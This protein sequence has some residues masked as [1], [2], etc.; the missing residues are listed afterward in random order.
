MVRLGSISA[1]HDPPPPHA[2]AFITG[3]AINTPI[4]DLGRRGIRS[5]FW[6]RTLL[7]RS[8]VIRKEPQNQPKQTFIFN[9]RPCGPEGISPNFF[10]HPYVERPPNFSG[11]HITACYNS[12]SYGTLVATIWCYNSGLQAVVMPLCDWD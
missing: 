5:G 3:P 12:K 11:V 2:T 9:F 10:P 1:R 6:N 8:E 4:L 7:D